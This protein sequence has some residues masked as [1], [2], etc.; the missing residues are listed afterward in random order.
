MPSESTSA[1]SR[2]IAKQVEVELALL[3]NIEKS[4]C[5]ALDWKTEDGR[6]VRKLSTLRFVAR[7][8]ERHLAH[9]RVLSDYGGYMHLVTDR[10]P[11]LVAAAQRLKE[12]RSALQMALER[13]NVRL[14]HLSPSDT[15]A[16]DDI[17]AD[18]ERYLGELDQHRRQE[19]ELFQHSFTQEQGGSG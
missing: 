19:L 11:Q 1:E 12:S 5:I 3:A 7:S 4:L 6:N 8:F 2:E 10:K 17:C 15:P 16:V 9:L 14:E 18:L 13:I